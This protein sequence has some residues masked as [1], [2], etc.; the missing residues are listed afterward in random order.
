[1]VVILSVKPDVNQPKV[2][3][4]PWEFR[5][6]KIKKICLKWLEIKKK[7]ICYRYIKFYLIWKKNFSMLRVI[8]F[9]IKFNGYNKKSWI[10]YWVWFEQFDDDCIIEKNNIE[11]NDILMVLMKMIQ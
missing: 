11:N 8:K 5:H 2:E 1:M 10:Y 6:W 9:L 3:I 7:H 4:P